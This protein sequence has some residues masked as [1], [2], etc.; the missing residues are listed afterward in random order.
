[1]TE[2]LNV[3]DYDT[4]FAA[5]D[6]ILENKLPELLVLFNNTLALGFEGHH[7]IIGL[8]SHFRDLMVCQH[9]VTLDLLEVGEDVKGQYGIQANKASREFLLKAI[10]LAND[11][12]LQ[13]R[14]SK[15]QR[16]LV[17]LTLMKLASV[18]YDGEKKKPDSLIPASLFSKAPKPKNGTATS[19]TSAV[20]LKNKIPSSDHQ[21]EE[22]PDKTEAPGGAV[23]DKAPM[24]IEPPPTVKADDQNISIKGPGRR[25]S[26]LSLSSLKVKMA[27]VERTKGP[28]IPLA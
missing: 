27:H 26:G 6:L 12:D 19:A 13:F 20:P 25:V 3:L 15:N 2:N 1:V 24:A 18:T 7:F 28:E 5:T 23:K 9:P 22:V 16:L 21:G 17:E 14:A 10:E 4:Y 11:C 8:A